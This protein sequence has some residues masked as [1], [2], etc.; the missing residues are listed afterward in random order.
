MFYIINSNININ[1]YKI[2][3][4]KIENLNYNKNFVYE[5]ELKINNYIKKINI[6]KINKNNIKEKKKLKSSFKELNNKIN[7]YEIKNIFIYRCN[8]INN[9]IDI[10]NK[11]KENLQNDNFKNDKF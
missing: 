4:D 11:K 1:F 6:K 5:K 9:K 3:K 7:K 8:V 10:I 2:K